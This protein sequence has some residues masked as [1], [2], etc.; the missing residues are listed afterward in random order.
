MKT[1]WWSI[2][3]IAAATGS[4]AAQ[5]ASP[6]ATDEAGVR[7]AAMD[8]MEGALTADA[9]RVARGVHEE[10]NKVTVVSLPR[11][12]PQVLAYNTATTLVAWVRGAG[13]Q[14]AGVDK[15]VEV[16][17]FDVGNDIATARAVGSLW[18]DLLQLAKRDGRWRIVNVLWAQR[19]PPAETR[20]DAA[21][22]RSEVEATALDYIDGA[23]SSD[24]ERMARAIHPE[25]HKVMLATNPRTG[26]SFLRKMGS[27]SLIEGTRSGLGALPKNE[28]N[29]EVEVQDVSHDMASVKVTSA[30]Y[31]DYLQMARVNGAWKIIN[32]LW[33]PNPD[34]PGRGG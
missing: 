17:V 4:A 14:L 23:Y 30:M 12:G 3:L 18:Y 28:R 13:Q 1:F 33:V 7:Q 8:Y 6:P 26:E 10:L 15:T 25:I 34:A 20:T 32:V 11:N 27:S 29:I 22:S 9:D 5:K 16:T 24:A 21:A 31:I 19:R 2:C